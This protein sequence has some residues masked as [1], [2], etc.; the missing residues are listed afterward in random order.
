MELY[1]AFSSSFRYANALIDAGEHTAKTTQRWWPELLNECFP[2]QPTEA[3][4][5]DSGEVGLG[6]LLA[7]LPKRN[8]GPDT[9]FWSDQGNR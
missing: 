4:Q 2:D 9:S 5:T 7:E 3:W 8:A 1:F 6:Q